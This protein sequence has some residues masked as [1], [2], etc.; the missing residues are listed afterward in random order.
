MIEI[1]WRNTATNWHIQWISEFPVDEEPHQTQRT[2]LR[3]QQYETLGNW[4][5]NGTRLT[6]HLFGK[7]QMANGLL[8]FFLDLTRLPT[9]LLNIR[10]T[11]KIHQDCRLVFIL[12]GG[13]ENS[14]RRLA[15]G[16]ESNE[17]STNNCNVWIYVGIKMYQ[18]KPCTS[19]RDIAVE[20]VESTVLLCGW[21]FWLP[22]RSIQPVAAG[23]STSWLC[24]SHVERWA[25]SQAGLT[26]DD[27][28]D[29]TVRK[30]THA[31]CVCVL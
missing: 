31:V 29:R 10:S 7:W 2:Y 8:D 18:V 17:R 23:A 11:A 22:G 25:K 6:R 5:A 28:G 15:T 14:K 3:G 21:D 1:D 9:F 24:Q 16:Q 30:K 12:P 19:L 26:W 4:M 20:D 27:P 13:I